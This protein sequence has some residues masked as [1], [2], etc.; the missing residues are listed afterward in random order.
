MLI[1][2]TVSGFT[3]YE[4]GSFLVAVIVGGGAGFLVGLVWFKDEPIKNKGRRAS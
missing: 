1:G 2:A 3:S 4:G